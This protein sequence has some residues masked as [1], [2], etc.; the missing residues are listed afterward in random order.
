MV[1]HCDESGRM[2]IYRWELKSVPD[3][4]TVMTEMAEFMGLKAFRFGLKRDG[5][6]SKTVFKFLS[7]NLHKMGFEVA[8]VLIDIRDKP[9]LDQMKPSHT[10]LRHFQVFTAEC[11][12]PLHHQE[13]VIT[14]GIRVV[15]IVADYTFQLSD[16]LFSNQ[17]WE[18]V[19]SRQWTDIEFAVKGDVKSCTFSAH[20]AILAARS[21][22]F[23]NLLQSTTS[24]TIKIDRTEPKAFKIFLRFLYTGQ[25]QLDK[26]KEINQQVLKLAEQYELAV[27][28]SLCKL[29]LEDIDGRE[30]TALISTFRPNFEVSRPKQHSK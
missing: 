2:L 16:V 10:E 17:L 25:F 8:K 20:R 29:A 7:T 28:T 4:G 26:Q 14:F 30:C 6:H 1:E 15:G 19:K 12:F 27:L 18:A 5:R 9:Q 22:V 11:E 3:K 23:H 13:V 24:T 21:P